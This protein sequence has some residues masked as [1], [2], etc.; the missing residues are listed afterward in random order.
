MFSNIYFK[1]LYRQNGGKSPPPLFKKK[2]V[3]TIFVLSPSQK[4]WNGCAFYINCKYMFRV[5][6]LTVQQKLD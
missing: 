6:N 1:I 5:Q 4:D 3:K 2:E